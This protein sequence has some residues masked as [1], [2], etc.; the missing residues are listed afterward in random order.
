MK[1]PFERTA[2]FRNFNIFIMEK[3]MTQILLHI[4]IIFVTI[5]WSINIQAEGWIQKSNVPFTQSGGVAFTI[6]QFSYIVSGYNSSSFVKS[7]WRYDPYADTWSQLS[8]FPGT[9]RW[10]AVGFNINGKG[11]ICCGNTTGGSGYL[12][13]L[14]EYD[15]DSAIWTRKAD[16]PTT[17]RINPVAFTIDSVAYVGCGLNAGAYKD[18][19]KYM[20]ATNTWI[21]VADFPITMEAGWAFESGGKGYVGGGLASSVISKKMWAYD[22]VADSWTAKADCPLG[23]EY[24]VSFSI[25]NI[26][27]VGTGTTS[28]TFLILTKLFYSYDP[29]TDSWSTVN[30]FT[31]AA[32]NKAFCFTN[33]GSAYLVTGDYGKGIFHDVWEFDVSIGINTAVVV[34]DAKIYPNPC[35]DYFIIDNLPISDAGLTVSL[36]NSSGEEVISKFVKLTRNNLV[37]NTDQLSPGFYILKIDNGFWFKTA[38]L[39][40]IE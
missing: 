19:Y 2:F 8:D 5:I 25:G 10:G 9:A 26:G 3:R 28:D 16:L 22:P 17:K 40:I 13:D 7:V 29:I 18:F 23:V 14:W 31:G 37:I 1:K 32:R 27:Y 36:T 39:M 38:K 11:Y 6:G 20:P 24:S 21:Q 15:P 4:A 34:S 33:N 35:K 12:K 30:G